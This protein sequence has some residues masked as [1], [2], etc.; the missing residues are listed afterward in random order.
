MH[1]LMLTLT[2][3][4]GIRIVSMYVFACY[5]ISM[6]LLKCVDDLIILVLSLFILDYSQISP[7]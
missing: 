4:D 1:L 7:E 5:L 3:E 6:L 2:W